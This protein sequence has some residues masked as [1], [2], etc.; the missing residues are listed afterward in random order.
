MNSAPTLR[1]LNSTEGNVAIIGDRNSVPKNIDRNNHVPTTEIVNNISEKNISEDGAT[2][3]PTSGDQHYSSPTTLCTPGGSVNCV[4]RLQQAACD[5]IESLDS[6]NCVDESTKKAAESYLISTENMRWG[7]SERERMTLSAEKEKER[8]AENYP[9]F[10]FR[11]SDRHD[12]VGSLNSL[13]NSGGKF[14]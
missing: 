9:G 13:P 14:F 7:S 6:L 1:M 4:P 12:S 11:T 5:F 2:K 10:A 3:L 8:K